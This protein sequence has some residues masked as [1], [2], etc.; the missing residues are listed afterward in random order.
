MI[1]PRDNEQTYSEIYGKAQ[2]EIKQNWTPFL[3]E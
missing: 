3:H 2:K 1:Q